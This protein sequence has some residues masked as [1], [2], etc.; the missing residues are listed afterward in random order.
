[1]N[2]FE[3]ILLSQK[4]QIYLKLTM[5]KSFYKQLLLIFQIVVTLKDILDINPWERKDLI[6]LKKILLKSLCLNKVTLFGLMY[7]L[8]KQNSTI[9][10]TIFVPN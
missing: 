9:F 6:E 5:E 10:E 4:N 3:N 1:M 2:S 7:Y 8:M